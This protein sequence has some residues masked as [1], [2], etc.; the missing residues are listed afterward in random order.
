LGLD[1]SELNLD[2]DVQ[3]IDLDL[4]NFRISGLGL[5]ER[6][7]PVLV[8]MGLD[9]TTCLIV[10]FGLDDIVNAHQS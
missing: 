6:G 8:T 3:H 9:L 2:F 7:L 10:E 5:G 1:T 4:D